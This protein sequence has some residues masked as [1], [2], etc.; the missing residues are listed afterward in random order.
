V[1]ASAPNNG[2]KPI[3]QDV[4]GYMTKTIERHPQV[5]MLLTITKE[6]ENNENGWW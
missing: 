5:V 6:K 1:F 4:S 2:T 3:I